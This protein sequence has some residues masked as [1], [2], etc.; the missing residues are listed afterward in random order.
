MQAPNN[1]APPPKPPRTAPVEE[2]ETV[3]LDVN[4]IVRYPLLIFNLAFWFVGF[5]LVAA[6]VY[7]LVDTIETD[8]DHDVLG[9]LTKHSLYGVLLARIEVL[10][11]IV[12]SL[13]FLL[14]FCGCVGALR[15]NTFL[16]RTYSAFL[17]LLVILNLLIGL[18]LVFVPGALKR[19][20]SQVF[21]ENMIIYYRETQDFQQLVD[22]VQ[23]TL[24]CCGMTDKSFRDWNLNMYFKCNIQNPSHERCSVPYS[25][26]RQNKTTTVSIFCGKGVLNMSDYEAWYRINIGNCPDAANRYVKQHVLVVAGG[27]LVAVI[28]L[29]FVDMI[30]RSLIDEIKVIRHIYMKVETAEAGMNA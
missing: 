14:A 3:I 10:V 28:V 15:E 16:L 26:C 22:S 7:T 30:T 8:E 19:I 29:S 6:G 4:P 20:F 9:T 12:G 23:K 2:E 17:T 13:L 18:M 25:C 1:P 24:E 27:C 21:S 11:I 5:G